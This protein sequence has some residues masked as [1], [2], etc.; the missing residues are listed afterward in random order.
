[1]FTVSYDFIRTFGAGVAIFTTL[2]VAVAWVLRVAFKA[3]SRIDTVEAAQG[4]TQKQ[5]DR[6]ETSLESKVAAVQIAI[7]SKVAG[8][9]G[10]MALGFEKMAATVAD[11]STKMDSASI[12]QS[13]Q[14]ESTAALVG[15]IDGKL[16]IISK[17]LPNG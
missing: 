16:D 3:H 6:L 5:V 7:D 15:R 2:V 9:H 12:R 1:M 17:Q 4:D 10:A 14:N 8:V 11:I 13:Q